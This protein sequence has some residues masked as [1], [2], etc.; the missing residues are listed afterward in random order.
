MHKSLLEAII[1]LLFLG[2]LVG[3]AM[4]LLKLFGGGTPEEYG[5]LGIGGGFWLISSAVA[6]AIRNKLA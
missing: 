1:L 3:F 6:I 5:V 4:A 2:G